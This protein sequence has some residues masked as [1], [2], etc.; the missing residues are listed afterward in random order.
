MKTIICPTDFSTNADH[1]LDYAIQLAKKLNAQ[2]VLLNAY[3]L[4]YS[5]TVISS[6]VMNI[7]K[8]T[9][10]A[11]L[12]ERCIRVDEA[13]VPFKSM[14][15]VGNPVRLTKDV[16][17]D[18]NADLV[19]IGSTGASEIEEIFMGSTTA[20]IMQTL[21]IPVLC[22]PH[23]AQFSLEKLV[24]ASDLKPLKNQDAIGFL[25]DFVKQS[26][27]RLDVVHVRNETNIAGNADKALFMT[28]LGSFSNSFHEVESEAVDECI[29][30]YADE[31]EASMLVLIARKRAFLERL[32]HVGISK[33]LSNYTARPL[34]MLHE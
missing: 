23:G 31:V 15:R 13:D 33:Q 20:S 3:Q 19:I 10:E 6:S 29:Q 28:Q 9:A 14:A 22:I 8:E 7:M 27:A 12:A 21:H 5:Q 17:N 32:F 4:P 16:A 1:A 24:L 11:G 26:G 2:I 25:K 30:T 18:L 34:L